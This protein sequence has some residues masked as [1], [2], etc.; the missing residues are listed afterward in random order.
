MRKFRRQ[1]KKKEQEVTKKPSVIGI[2]GVVLLFFVILLIMA[3]ATDHLQPTGIQHN[4]TITGAYKRETKYRVAKPKVIVK[5]DDGT[6]ARILTTR[7]GAWQTGKRITV[8]EMRSKRFKR[9]AFRFVKYFNIITHYYF[10]LVL[11]SFP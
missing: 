4:G 8:E 5:L 2:A 6:M 1:K 11:I 7:M 3:L 10:S 9:K